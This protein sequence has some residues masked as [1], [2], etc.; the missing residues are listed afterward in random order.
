MRYKN[1]RHT[2]LALLLLLGSAATPAAQVKQVQMHIGG[3]LCG[4]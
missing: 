2:M 3:Y 1:H 4:N